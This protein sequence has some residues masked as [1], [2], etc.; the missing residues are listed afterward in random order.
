MSI[1]VKPNT[2]LFLQYSRITSS[3]LT[4]AF[5]ILSLVHF[6]LQVSFQAWAFQ[7]NSSAGAFL[8]DILT[9]GNFSPHE[10][11]A[12]LVPLSTD[13]KSGGELRLCNKDEMEAHE[14]IYEC[15]VAWKGRIV[16]GP[17]V[18]NYA[19]VPPASTSTSAA[20]T[21]PTS[22][23][24]SGQAG[25]I[26]PVED[27]LV[28][29]N[30]S[31]QDPEDSEDKHDDDEDDHDDRKWSLVSRDHDLTKIS[32][33][34]IWRRSSIPVE[35]VFTER[36]VQVGSTATQSVLSGVRLPN[37]MNVTTGTMGVVLSEQCVQMIIWPNQMYVAILPR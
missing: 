12:V 30:P 19:A 31:G 29:G 26:T 24:S 10:V 13:G 14:D 28:V 11:F 36:L 5:F 35:S 1:E 16:P 8:S 25:G 33:L 7:I 6:I 15:P 32:K 2:N 27:I 9:A 21:T 4:T 3:R 17:N 20:V 34:S 22:G 18:T 37:M 23:G